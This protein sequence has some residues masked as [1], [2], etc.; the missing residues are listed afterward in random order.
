[1]NFKFVKGDVGSA[2]L[3][4]YVMRS[5]QIDT[6]MHFAAQTHVDNSFGNSFEFTENN[7]RGTHVLLETIK[8]LGTIKRFLHV[9]TDEVYGESS[10]EMDKANVEAAS[11]LEPTNPYSA[12]KAGAEMLV[13]A[14]G[15]SYGL[16]YVITRGNNV[17][18][19]H[20]YPEKAIPKFI[21]LARNG[22][23]IPIHG[24]GQATRSYMHV[25]DAAS[26]FDTILHK[27]ELKGVYNIGA[28]E[29]R[30]V[31]SVA[32]DIG[33]ALGVDIDKTITH[34]Q[35]RKF[36][37]R[38]YFIDCSKLLALGWTQKVSWEE[39]LKETIEWYTKNDEKS[40]YWG[41]L[42]GALVAHPTGGKTAVVGEVYSNLEDMMAGAAIDGP[43]EGGDEDKKPT[44]L[45]YGRTGWIG[46]KLGK[47]LTE[48]GHRWMYGAGRLEDRASIL[49]DVKRSKCTHI[50]CAAGV[51]GRPNVDWCEDHKTETIR[52]NVIGVLNLCDVA[53]ENDVHVTNFATGCIYKYDDEHVIGGKPFTETDD[54]NFGGSFYSETK[55]YMEMMLR[56]YP[57][58]MQ[59]RVR[60]PIDGDLQNPR[61]FIT[62]IANYAKVVNIPNSMTVLEEFVPMAVEGALRKLTG[63]YNWTNPGAISHNEVLELYRDYLHPE[64]TWEN[65]TEEEQA[66]VIKAPR[67]NNTMCGKKIRDA[68]PQVLDIKQ[69]IIKHVMEPNK[70]KGMKA[71]I[72]REIKPAK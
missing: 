60:M 55:S 35:D 8:T 22:A 39:G 28:H 67:S 26:A 65:F 31:L 3:M 13:M 32:R 46:G 70:A 4:T 48:Q 64:F 38:R 66:E 18:G 43:D 50:L 49:D 42:S 54:P 17:Y 20:Q 34:V 1:M 59:L 11:L 53:L 58:V 69:S 36:N 45:V 24:D 63:A 41:N 10:Y 27:G 62:K 2:D 29:E 19:P 5:E 16:P 52:A 33:V 68:F 6:V 15:R 47:L 61:N 23:R 30:T 71:P 56:H 12:T 51:T 40:G 21:M 9:S 25:A 44:F 7:I 57:N 37:D 14:Y 72:K